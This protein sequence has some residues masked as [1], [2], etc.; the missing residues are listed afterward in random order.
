MTKHKD[1][2]QRK[3][4][5]TTW[6][7]VREEIANYGKQGSDERTRWLKGPYDDHTWSA[8][9]SLF[10]SISRYLVL[11]RPLNGYYLEFGGYGARTMRLAFDSFRHVSD[12]TYVE[13]DSFQGLPKVSGGD[14]QGETWLQGHMAMPEADFRVKCEEFGIPKERLLTIP[15]FYDATLNYTLANTL[16]PDKAAVVFIDS[17]LYSSAKSVLAF[18]PPL[19]QPGTIIVFDDWYCF[20]GDPNKGEQRAWKEFCAQH[21]DGRFVPFISTHDAQS[22]I[23]LGWD[24]TAKTTPA[25]YLLETSD[26]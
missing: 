17:D 20:Y 6:K 5:V 1:N 18:L 19:L 2:R 16:L 3:I 14:V 15:G 24:A 26:D 12:L 7:Q 11:N 4:P 8:K 22:F 13:F 9:E 10:L 21:P 23:F 25:Q